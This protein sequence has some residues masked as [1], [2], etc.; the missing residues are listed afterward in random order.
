MSREAHQ[1]HHVERGHTE[2]RHNRHEREHEPPV[3]VLLEP[4]ERLT[5][6]VLRADHIRRPILEQKVSR[7]RSKNGCGIETSERLIRVDN[8]PTAYVKSSG[9]ALVPPDGSEVFSYSDLQL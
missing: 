9:A 6:H 3:H 8:V 5:R 7:R 2:C 4:V 1:K